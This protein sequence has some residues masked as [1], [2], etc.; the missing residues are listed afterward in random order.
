MATTAD[1]SLEKMRGLIGDFERR[2]PPSNRATA[3]RLAP[4]LLDELK[5]RI[6]PA[7]TPLEIN[8]L[9]GLPLYYDTALA[10]P[11]YV[12]EY[13]DGTEQ[14]HDGFGMNSARKAISRR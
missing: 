10:Y 12:I 14:L 1:V 8:T 5:D 13:A 3:V 4:Q 7:M 9:H 11:N 6:P 2:F